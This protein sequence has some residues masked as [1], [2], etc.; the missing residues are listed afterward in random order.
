MAAAT[1]SQ[2]QIRPSF[3]EKFRPA[4]VKALVAAVLSERLAD[5]TCAR[6]PALFPQPRSRLLPLLL[7]PT[8]FLTQVQSGADGAVDARDF[9]RDQESAEERFGIAALQVCRTGC[10]RR[11]QRG[12]VYAWA[13]AAS[14]M[15]TLTT[16]PRSRSKTCASPPGIER[17]PHPIRPHARAHACRRGLRAPLFGPAALTH[18]YTRLLTLA[19]PCHKLARVRA[20]LAVLRRDGVWCVH[21]LSRRA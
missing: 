1:E 6:P 12:E 10:R 18:T 16:M 21:I 19:L 5:K 17:V 15:Q 4:T 20:G 2:Y 13:A 8:A 11:E 14:G 3:A 9:R 7:T